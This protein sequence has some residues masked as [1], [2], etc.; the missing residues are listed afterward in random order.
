MKGGKSALWVDINMADTLLSQTV[1]YIQ[2]H[3]NEPFFLY[4]AMHQPHVPRVP[5]PRFV[6]RSGMGP[7]GDVILEADWCV[8][9]LLDEL[10]KLGLLENTLIFFSSDNGPVIDNGYQDQTAELIGKHRP[11][12]LLRGGKG[13][14]FEGGTHVPFVVHWPAQIKP[15]VSDA[16]SI[17]Y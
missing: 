12:G 7:R 13:S 15:G 1:N 17:T 16:I 4:Y 8:G 6:G 9:V 5:N 14:L 11:E 3:Q 10:K 2:T